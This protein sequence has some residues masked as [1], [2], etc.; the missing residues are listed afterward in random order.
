M[1]RKHPSPSNPSNRGLEAGWLRRG[2]RL[3]QLGRSVG[4]HPIRPPRPPA[5]HLQQGATR[6]HSTLILLS[7]PTLPNAPPPTAPRRHS[8]RGR[9]RPSSSSRC[10]SRPPPATRPA[11]SHSCRR[12]LPPRWRTRCRARCEARGSRVLFGRSH[13]FAIFLCLV[14]PALLFGW[15][16]NG[17]LILVGGGGRSPL[18]RRREIP[19]GEIFSGEERIREFFSVEIPSG[20]WRADSCGGGRSPGPPLRPVP[21]P[22]PPNSTKM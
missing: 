8:S 18:G 2:G 16:D 20:R 14:G 6:S 19:S 17:E 3:W 7:T 13:P 11:R 4:C 5:P 9:W 22:G 12:P 15:P 1:A 21:R 10:S